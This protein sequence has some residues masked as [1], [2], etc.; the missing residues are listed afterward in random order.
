M[1]NNDKAPSARP[2]FNLNYPDR[3]TETFIMP[4]R[5][6]DRTRNFARTSPRTTSRRKT[7]R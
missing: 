6:A 4:D 5:P 3:K 1:T 2:A 7:T